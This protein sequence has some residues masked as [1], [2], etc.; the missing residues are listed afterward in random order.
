[1]KNRLFAVA[2][3]VAFL[4][5]PACWAQEAPAPSPKENPVVVLTT[6]LG[7]IEIELYE[8]EAPITVD[9]FLIIP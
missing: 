5:A 6:S 1:M 3:G 2:A 7:V 8:E 4:V 9:N